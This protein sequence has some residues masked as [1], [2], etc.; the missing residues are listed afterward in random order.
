MGSSFESGQLYGDV[1][2]FN[3]GIWWCFDDEE[4]YQI[5][6]L[7]EDVYYQEN[8]KKKDANKRQCQCQIIYYWWFILDKRFFYQ[9]DIL[10]EGNSLFSITQI[11]SNTPWKISM[12]LR[13]KS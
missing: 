5:C 6:Q 2:D 11:S 8:Y 13:N 12:V 4:I 10:L 3:T 7:P 9:P 1:L